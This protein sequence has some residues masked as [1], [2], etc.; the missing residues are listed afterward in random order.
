MYHATCHAEAVTST[1]SLAARLRTELATGSRTASRSG[2]PEAQS[3][4]GSV[5][6]SRLTPPPTKLRDSS[7]SPS[8]SPLSAE[9]K[10]AGTKRKVEQNDSA[11]TG[12]PDGTPPFKKLALSPSAMATA[13]A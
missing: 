9:S 4:A 10:L 2:T 6:H 12:E 5:S 7:K 1:N 3:S 8:L 11:V 13:T